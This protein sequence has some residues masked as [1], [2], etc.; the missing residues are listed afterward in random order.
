MKLSLYMNK[1]WLSSNMN[2]KDAVGN[3]QD[4]AFSSRKLYFLWWAV[5][6]KTKE[7]WTLF[8]W[9]MDILTSVSIKWFFFYFASPSWWDESGSCSEVRN[10]LL[11]FTPDESWGM[12]HII[13]RPHPEASK[14]QK[15]FTDV[16]EE[17]GLLAKAQKHTCTLPFCI[18]K[19]CCCIG[20]SSSCHSLKVKADKGGLRFHYSKKY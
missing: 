19:V 15:Q 8:V 6:T 4:A 18:D 2:T 9:L 17:I 20:M 12:R 1:S 14:K 16:W 10:V 5:H 13:T 11:S 7:P 3:R